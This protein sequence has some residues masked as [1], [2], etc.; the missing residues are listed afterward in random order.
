MAW[1]SAW[2]QTVALWLLWSILSHTSLM[3]LIYFP[4]PP[5]SCVFSALCS[6]PVSSNS[7]FF[8][9]FF[10]LP[11]NFSA[12]SLTFWDRN[13][14]FLLPSSLLFNGKI[15]VEPVWVFSCYFLPL[16]LW[17]PTNRVG[18]FILSFLILSLVEISYCALLFCIK[19][20]LLCRKDWRFVLLV[21][22]GLCWSCESWALSVLT[23][24]VLCSWQVVMAP[25]VLGAVAG[26][27]NSFISLLLSFLRG[28]WDSLTFSPIIAHLWMFYTVV[29]DK[30]ESVP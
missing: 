1:R 7:P 30:S 27:H 25:V 18:F 6:F 28:D 20:F 5:S 9:F 24:K 8:F 29:K 19:V 2:V 13:I 26:S 12:A 16:H 3:S 17:S 23:Q 22:A 14:F 4:P 15:A 10:K 21:P 11:F